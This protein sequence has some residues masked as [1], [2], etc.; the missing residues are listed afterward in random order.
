MNISINNDQDSEIKKLQTR[1][2][3]LEKGNRWYMDA[4]SKLVLM[5]EVYGIHDAKS[6]IQATSF[7]VLQAI[8]FDL[9][10]F[11][12][13]NEDDASF[14]LTHMVSQNNLIDVEGLKQSLINSGEF[15]WALLQNRTV[16]VE[17]SFIGRNILMHVLTTKKRIRGI[18]IGVPEA[19]YTP[20]VASQNLLSVVL[21]NS[22]HALESCA[23]YDLIKNK[24]HELKDANVS[25]EQKVIEKTKS[26]Q[27]ALEQAQDATKAKSQFLANM[28]HEIRTPMNAIVGFTQLLQQ[29]DLPPGQQEYVMHIDTAGQQLLDL[30]N[31][32]LDFSKM[33][34]GKLIMEKIPFNLFHLLE[35][36][37]IIMGFS[38]NEKKIP[39]LFKIPET[40]K[41]HLDGDPHRLGQILTNLLSNAIKFTHEGEISLSISEEIDSENQIIYTKFKV[42]DTGI[43]MTE[44]QTKSIFQLFDQADASTTRKYGGTGLGLAISEQ[45]ATL[46]GGEIEVHSEYG[47]GSTFTLTLPFSYGDYDIA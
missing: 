18:F 36:L 20:S 4:M 29:E 47:V 5:N 19:D 30:I 33:E 15:S 44:A 27:T 26:L 42:T 38:A 6:I 23:L 25:L 13:V 12:L 10:A 34:A 40:L 41:Q 1:I 43:G 31:D 37:E 28:S 46:M 21:Q 3:Y 8:D 39:L 35:K 14:K 32:I 11:F 16:E 7:H 24:N 22:A 45:L 2:D 9:A 17:N